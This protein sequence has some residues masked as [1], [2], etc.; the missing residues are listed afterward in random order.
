MDE[1]TVVSTTH[2]EQVCRRTTEAEVKA[3]IDKMKLQ[4]SPGVDNVTVAMLKYAGLCFVSML[5]DVINATFHEGKIPDSL[6][7]RRM[8][9]I[10]KK[11]PS[12]LV[13]NKRPLTVSCVFL[14]VITKIM[15]G[16]M[17]KIC[18][19]NGYY[20]TV[21]YGFRSGR[22]TSDCVFM[23]LAAVIKAKK[24]SVSSILRHC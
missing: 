21:Q 12:L 1:D 3:V 11:S 19:K 14:S 23:L 20:G 18:E 24:N 2:E 8:T 16:R 15:H 4:R 17:D 22:S 13:S 10:D 5:T 6:L 7:V 9:L